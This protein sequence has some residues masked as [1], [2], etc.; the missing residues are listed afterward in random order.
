MA[1]DWE[2]GRVS[3]RLDSCNHCGRCIAMCPFGSVKAETDGYRIYLGGRWGK[4]TA[5]GIPMQKIFTDKEEVMKTVEKAIL[6][7][8]DQ[9]ITG[10][11]FADMAEPPADDKG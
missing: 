10:E 1:A 2:N 4:K 7:F 11:R 8:R 3:I 9:G 6:L 5:H